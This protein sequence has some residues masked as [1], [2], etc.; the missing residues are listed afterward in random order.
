LLDKDEEIA[1]LSQ[2]LVE[3]EKR[4]VAVKIQSEIEMQRVKEVW[5]TEVNDLQKQLLKSQLQQYW[6]EVL[7]MQVN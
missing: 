3:K 1:N 2:V 6:L 4:L 5:R 7:A